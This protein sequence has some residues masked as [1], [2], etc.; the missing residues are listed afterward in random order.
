MPRAERVAGRARY[1]CAGLTVRP[2]PGTPD[3]AVE[4]VARFQ[5]S[6]LL[7]IWRRSRL[8]KPFK[9]RIFGLALTQ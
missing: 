8:W 3:K 9:R 7:G 6:E 4:G 2:R 5:G 1:E